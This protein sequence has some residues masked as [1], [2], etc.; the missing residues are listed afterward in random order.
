MTAT[1]IKAELEAIEAEYASI[2][3]MPA[4]GVCRMYNVDTRE[5]IEAIMKADI[6]ILVKELEAERWYDPEYAPEYL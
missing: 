6:E 2:R 5:D 4:A 1:G 3:S